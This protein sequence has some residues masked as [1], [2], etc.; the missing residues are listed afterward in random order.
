[1][2]PF[3]RL[4]CDIQPYAWGQSDAISTLVG[5]PPSGEPEAE[6]W[7]GAHPKAPSRLRDG[8]TLLEA[9]EAEPGNFLGAEVDERF[10]QLPFL[11][12]LLAAAIPLS[13][14]AHPDLDRAIAGF[15]REN[16]LGIAIDAP[17]RTYRDPNHKPE[18]ICALTPFEA[19]CG[20]RS[21]EATCRLFDALDDG[22]LAEVRSL[23]SADNDDATRLRS[24]MSF[25]LGLGA[26]TAAAMADAVAERAADL[27]RQRHPI[28]GEFGPDLAA[29]AQVAAAFP[30]DIG[31][32][33]ALLLNHV[34]LAPG[35]ALYLG[36]GNLHA[37]L[38][39]VGVELMANSDNVLRGGLT[40]KHIDIDEL[41]S[42]VD[43]RPIDVPVQRPSGPI[44]TYDSPVAEFS[45]TRV[46]LSAEAF[47]VDGPAIVFVTQGSASLGG[48]PL[49]VGVPAFVPA[50]S[51]PIPLTGSGLAWGA[52][53]GASVATVR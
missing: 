38:Q 36:S 4:D 48:S 33:V 44:H 6:L 25:L 51:G 37:Y 10:G 13:I 31:G 23:L 47:L 2:T 39:G 46:E 3:E 32:V 17:E 35:E 45:L 9:I 29:C 15:A 12:K 24:V 18:L 50:S 40:P 11:F 52:G 21:L 7:M 53:V 49:E 19:K 20:F 34:V 1:M 16:E 28:A 14:Q 43:Y 41:L 22:R 8:R 26:E 42:V 27:L 30:G 5:K